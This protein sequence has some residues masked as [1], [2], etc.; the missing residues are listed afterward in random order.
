MYIPFP[1]FSTCRLF[2]VFV[3][4]H[5][6]W[7]RSLCVFMM[8]VLCTQIMFRELSACLIWTIFLFRYKI[9]HYTGSLLHEKSV[10]E[11]WEVCLPWVILWSSWLSGR[12]RE[13]N[14]WLQ[15][16]RLS[17][18]RSCCAKWLRDKYFSVWSN[19]TRSVSILSLIPPLLSLTMLENTT[20]IE[21]DYVIGK[22]LV[23]WSE[24]LVLNEFLMCARP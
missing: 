12:A 10:S 14:I 17:M 5:I 18:G 19:L 20:F 21:F 11:L 2:S 9:W 6:K 13:V 3:S 1:L 22:C 7:V 23:K 4:C 8:L 24:L 15:M 16:Y